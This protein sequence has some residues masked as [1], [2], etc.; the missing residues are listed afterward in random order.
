MVGS[1]QNKMIKLSVMLLW[2]GK[3]DS[4]ILFT[5]AMGVRGVM[6][7]VE[8]YRWLGSVRNRFADAK[9]RCGWD[10]KGIMVKARQKNTSHKLNHL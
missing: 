6:I 8:H 10:L 1:L 9:S 7:V 3:N 2:K 5:Q 4:T